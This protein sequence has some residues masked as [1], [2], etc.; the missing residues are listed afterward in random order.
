MLNFS[1]V[2]GHIFRGIR[3]LFTINFVKTA[4]LSSAPLRRAYAEGLEDLDGDLENP[5]PE[6]TK[7]FD[8][9]ESGS[10]TR[11]IQKWYLR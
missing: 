4:D 8:A 5:Y 1:K 11:Q 9:W 7:L 10:R 2:V 6:G 3:G